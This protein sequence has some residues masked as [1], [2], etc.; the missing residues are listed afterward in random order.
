MVIQVKFSQVASTKQLDSSLVVEAIS[1]V[2]TP[3][4]KLG[5]TVTPRMTPSDI[6]ESL[7]Y[8][9]ANKSF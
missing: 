3:V 5:E 6:S 1:P 4:L 7:R 8:L 2:E 9:K